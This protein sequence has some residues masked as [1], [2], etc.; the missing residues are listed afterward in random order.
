MKLKIFQEHKIIFLG[1]GIENYTLILWLRRQGFNNEITV[2][3]PLAKEQSG[4]RYQTLKND[5]HILWSFGSKMPNLMNYSL[6]IRSSGVLIDPKLRKELTKKKILSSAIQLF[7]DL[8]PTKN[9]IGITGTK[10]KGIT[11]SLIY[12]I[13]KTAK[14]QVWF[15]ANIGTPLFSFISKIKKN[16]W[17]VLELSSFQLQELTKSPKISVLTNFSPEHLSSDDAKNPNFHYSLSDYFNSKLKIAKYQK[18][19]DIFVINKKLRAKI[20]KIKLPGKV[21]YF[22]SSNLPS[23]LPGEHNKENIAAAELVAKQLKVSPLTITKAVRSFKGLEYRLQKVTEKNSISYYNDSF[24]TTPAS[25]LTALRTF[26]QPIILLAGGS[27]KG[28][29]FTELAKLI[30]QKVKYIILFKGKGSDRLS[31]AL[32]KVNFPKQNTV[33]V[34]SMNKAMKLARSHARS[35][36]IILLS[37]ACASFGVFKN[38]KERGYQFKQA[39]LRR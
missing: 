7:F 28:S 36:D 11:S 34:D 1:L 29:D 13:L 30:K 15:G 5:N 20:K 6:V 2:W 24:A 26:S 27:D 35:G 10:G 23:I 9:I 25:T 17:V 19:S 16:D 39:S 32:K 4:P 33:V 21:I 31:H 18:K 37:P 14:K 22:T 3:N 12:T 8:C 38:Y